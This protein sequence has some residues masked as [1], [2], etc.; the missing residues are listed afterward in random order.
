MEPYRFEILNF[1][2]ELRFSGPPS[3]PINDILKPFLVS[4]FGYNSPPTRITLVDKSLDGLDDSEHFAK[5]YTSLSIEPRGVN[6]HLFRYY[7]GQFFVDHTF[8]RVKMW[9]PFER[10]MSIDHDG[11]ANFSGDPALRLVLWGRASIEGYCYMHGALIVL[12]GKYIL[13]IG[14]S[15]SGKT[16]LSRFACDCGAT[17]LTEE[18]PFLA[19]KNSR[20]MVH[21]TPWPGIKGPEFPFCDE[22]CAIFFLRHANN[23]EVRAL[24]VAEVIPLL[25]FHS[26][27][28]NWLPETIPS[29]IEIFNIVTR[30]IPCYDFGFVP[31][32]SSVKAIRDIL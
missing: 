5:R 32:H 19:I 23:N 18:D 12:D 1:P 17:C 30:D 14:S 26:R 2:I 22:L 11:F 24:S 15:G 10:Q 3:L 25:L 27:T 20:V 21:G 7:T 6:G 16:T 31:D 28:F 29:A 13:L 9:L 4:E 8:T